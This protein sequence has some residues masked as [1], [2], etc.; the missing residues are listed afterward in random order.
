MNLE[1]LLDNY[2]APKKGNELL[3]KLIENKLNEDVPKIFVPS[4]LDIEAGKGEIEGKQKKTA[5]YTEYTELLKNI[6]G[7]SPFLYQRIDKVND[8]LLRPEKII[9]AGNIKR[10]FSSFL[11]IQEIRENLLNT[12]E[13]VAG[14][15]AETIMAQ[16]IDGSNEAN[17]GAVDI[18]SQKVFKGGVQLK[19][20]SARDPDNPRS[21]D[22]KVGG[23]FTQLIEYY[24]ESPNYF[25]I[26]I[27]KDRTPGIYRFFTFELNLKGF[28]EKL[29]LKNFKEEFR[30]YIPPAN[31][32]GSADT[33]QRF[34]KNLQD[35]F[36]PNTNQIF[37]PSLDKIQDQSP[38]Y[39][40]RRYQ[41]LKFIEKYREII[42]GKEEFT[43]PTQYS[44]NAAFMSKVYA[45]RTKPS[46]ASYFTGELDLRDEVLN[47][48]IENYRRTLS[49]KMFEVLNLLKT[50]VQTMNKFFSTRDQSTGY[51][52]VNNLSETTVKFDQY[53][54]KEEQP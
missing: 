34:I 21:K 13:S 29:E 36:D 45:D 37:I 50:S 35:M 52:T 51:Q 23:S 25:Y 10:A 31:F 48:V 27:L 49:G 30:A 28:L 15:Q 41:A 1:E 11:L 4:P 39:L 46:E 40:L 38:E 14:F 47:K 7:N 19:T 44:L 6:K 5:A 53:F 43:I 2:Y 26:I 24:Q 33:F 16:L 8:F 20:L 18:E 9:R 22:P 3:I 12:D 42:P 54:I 17:N 32:R